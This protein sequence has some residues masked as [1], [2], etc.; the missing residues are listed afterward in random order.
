[1]LAQLQ[2]HEGNIKY[3]NEDMLEIAQK[4]YTDLFTPSKTNS[5]TQD[6]LLKNIKK[7]ITEQQKIIMDAPL[8]IQELTKAMTNMPLKKS[9]GMDGLPIEFYKTFWHLIDH[10]YLEYLHEIQQNAFS[11]CKNTSLIT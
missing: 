2:D 5:K 7:Q 3:Q 10:V 9:P 4:F 1:M 11:D 6:K 8:S